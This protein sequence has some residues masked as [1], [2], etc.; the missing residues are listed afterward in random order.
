M[1]RRL[2]PIWLSLTFL[3]VVLLWLLVTSIEDSIPHIS[4]DAFESLG[5]RYPPRIGDNYSTLLIVE[6]IVFFLC[7]IA[8][9]FLLINVMARKVLEGR[10]ATF[11][12]FIKSIDYVW[13]AFGSF[14]VFLAVTA[15]VEELG[16]REIDQLSLRVEEGRSSMSE[17]IVEAERACERIIIGDLIPNSTSSDRISAFHHN[18][19]CRII[20]QPSFR[21]WRVE[22]EVL[23]ACRRASWYFPGSEDPIYYAPNLSE[24]DR[25]R[26]NATSLLCAIAGRLRVDERNLSIERIR[27]SEITSTSSNGFFWYNV[28]LLIAAIRL[29]K[30]THE[31]FFD[32]RVGG[33]D[34]KPNPNPSP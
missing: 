19:I 26:I 8:L 28:F 5:M 11:S 10:R 32:N 18:E 2:V 4:R 21:W 27:L 7:A 24:E 3:C 12:K 29:T 13:Y 20:R 9:A 1:A 31:V 23:S 16:N 33:S 30:T 22:D 15:L 17:R 14:S 34:A 6:Y 25:E